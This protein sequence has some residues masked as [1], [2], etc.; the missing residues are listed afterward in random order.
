MRKTGEQQSNLYIYICIYIY[1]YIYMHIYIYIRTYIYIYEQI[2]SSLRY[3]PTISWISGY[4]SELGTPEKGLF[5]F[6]LKL[7]KNLWSQS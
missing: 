6:I 1:V 3:L 2:S 5:I 7:D 4:E